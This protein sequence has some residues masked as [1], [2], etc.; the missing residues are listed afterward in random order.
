MLSDAECC[1]YFSAV[2]IPDDPFVSCLIDC[3]STCFASR[4]KRLRNRHDGFHPVAEILSKWREQ[5]RQPDCSNDVEK[6]VPR[7]PA[8][9]SRKGCMRGKG[10]P[11]NPHCNYRGVR[12]RTWGKWVA[13]IREPNR[14]SRLW[15]GTFDTALDAAMAYDEAARAMYGPYARVNLPQSGIAAQDTTLENAESYQSATTTSQHSNVFGVEESGVKVPKLEAGDE[16]RSVS[17][18]RSTAE[19]V[20]SMVK[21]KA[22]EELFKHF[23][24]LQDLPQDMFGVEDILGNRDL[25]LLNSNTITQSMKSEK[26]QVEGVDPNTIGLFDTPSAFASA[27]QSPDVKS[28][29][30]WCPMEQRPADMDYN[31]EFIRHMSQDVEF[32]VNDQGIPELEFL[33][34]R[35]FP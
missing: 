21:T 24:S 2:L 12:Q 32:R 26:N 6:Y 9:G 3:L 13:E 35:L 4:K 25:Y 15:L 29:G 34:P 33:D 20:M 1:D 27:I 16:T 19:P 23:D 17:P 7:V 14:G 22:D 31:S 11:E 10:G 18:P 8:K 28:L 30:T 5:N